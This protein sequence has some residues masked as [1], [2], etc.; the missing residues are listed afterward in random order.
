MYKYLQILSVNFGSY[1]GLAISTLFVLLTLSLSGCGGGSAQSSPVITPDPVPD[2][3][4]DPPPIDPNAKIPPPGLIHS[5]GKIDSLSSPPVVEEEY[6][7]AS[8]K[9][10]F[11]L[12]K[13]VINGTAK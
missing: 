6:T 11:E 4:P 9:C 3:I 13:I 7:Q 1:F 5:T 2:P 12:L 8:S 10:R